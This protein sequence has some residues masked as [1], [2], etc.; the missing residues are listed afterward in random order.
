M[1]RRVVATVTVT[2]IVIES[3]DIVMESESKGSS[4]SYSHRIQDYEIQDK[5]VSLQCLHY[6]IIII[7]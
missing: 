5:N 4:Y 1:S 2:V 7:G 6:I 3:L